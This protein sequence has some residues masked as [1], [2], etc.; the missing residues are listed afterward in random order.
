MIT[1]IIQPVSLTCLIILIFSISSG[2]LR[3]L[4]NFST[5]STTGIISISS[6]QHAVITSSVERRCLEICQASNNCW[7]DVL[8]SKSTH[9]RRRSDQEHCLAVSITTAKGRPSVLCIIIVQDDWVGQRMPR[10][11]SVVFCLHCCRSGPSSFL[12]HVCNPQ[13]EVT[14]AFSHGASLS[15][16]S[17]RSNRNPLS[18]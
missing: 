1:I 9:N 8:D 18:S 11:S 12:Y 16:S 5:L 7:A 6:F 2:L 13:F 17:R 3:W 10:S 4:D 15:N 14:Q